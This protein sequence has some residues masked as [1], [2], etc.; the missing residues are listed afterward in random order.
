MIAGV[1]GTGRLG[2]ENKNQ[3]DMAGWIS[4]QAYM[5]RGSGGGGY[6]APL[7]GG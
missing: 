2:N 4:L 3:K 5:G 6:H 1:R 7:P